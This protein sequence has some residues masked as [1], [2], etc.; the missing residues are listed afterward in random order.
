V[1]DIADIGREGAASLNHALSE[2]YDLV[3]DSKPVGQSG[4]IKMLSN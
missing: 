2:Y 4:S 3:P 1:F